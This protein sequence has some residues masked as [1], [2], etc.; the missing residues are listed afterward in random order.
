MYDLNLMLLDELTVEGDGTVTGAWVDL[1]A[2]NADVAPQIS[3]YEVADPPGSG[4]MIRPL[5]WQLVIPSVANVVAGDADVVVA[6]AY[7]DDGA[8]V[9]GEED[10]FAT[11][12]DL[13]VATN[14]PYIDRMKFI[15]QSRFVRFE[16][17]A[18]AVDHDLVGVSLGPVD[19]GEYTSF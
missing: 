11:L 15:T 8:A 1:W 18:M 12:P 10:V 2:V 7:G 16:I 4:G 3:A 5:V 13:N 9:N 14:F 17:R 19:G 6:L